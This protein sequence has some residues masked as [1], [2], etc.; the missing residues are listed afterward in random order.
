MS[1]MSLFVATI[2][3]SS[4]CWYDRVSSSFSIVSFAFSLSC[5][6]SYLRFEKRRFSSF[7]SRFICS[8]VIFYPSRFVVMYP[9][10]SLW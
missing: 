4:S 3:S 9:Y 10:G 7:I 8:S 1:S 5:P 2:L 6:K